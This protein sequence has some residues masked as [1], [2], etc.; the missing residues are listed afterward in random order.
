VAFAAGA[1]LV[2]T[3][4]EPVDALLYDTAAVWVCWPLPASVA[5]PPHAVINTAAL[6]HSN[7]LTRK[8]LAMETSFFIGKVPYFNK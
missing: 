2:A 5:P 6:Q 8:S 3:A 4:P 1:L 7:A